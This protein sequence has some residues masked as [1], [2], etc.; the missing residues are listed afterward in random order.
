MKQGIESL[1]SRENS[2]Y[3]NLDNS[4]RG[5]QIPDSADKLIRQYVKRIIRMERSI[6]MVLGLF[7]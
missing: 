6:A 2:S 3:Q 7:I 4:N 1:E 5:L